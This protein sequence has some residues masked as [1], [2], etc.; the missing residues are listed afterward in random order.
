MFIYKGVSRPRWSRG[1]YTFLGTV[2]RRRGLNLSRYVEK[3]LRIRWFTIDVAISLDGL[4]LLG[5]I[6]TEF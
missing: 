2:F 3:V 4:G 6:W 5:C 1:V